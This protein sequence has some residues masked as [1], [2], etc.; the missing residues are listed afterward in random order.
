MFCNSPVTSLLS[1]LYLA[2]NLLLF[3][4]QFH[5]SPTIPSPMPKIDI[6]RLSKSAHKDRVTTFAYESPGHYRVGSEVRLEMA[7]HL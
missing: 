2:K 6:R 7:L 1:S 5:I 3:L 4:P